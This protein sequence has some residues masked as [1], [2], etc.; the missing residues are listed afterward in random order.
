MCL[1][2][3]LIKQVVENEKNYSSFEIIRTS[4]HLKET[5]EASNFTQNPPR[6]NQNFP[7]FTQNLPR[8]TQN[9]PKFTRN[10]Q[11]SSNIFYSKGTFKSTSNSSKA[12]T[13]HP[14][15]SRVLLKTS[16][17]ELNPPRLS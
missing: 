16:T 4:Q 3:S 5:Q 12:S 8:F 11:F 14:Q 7:R 17:V 2:N 1:R 9:L 15:I 10:L 13:V 6:F